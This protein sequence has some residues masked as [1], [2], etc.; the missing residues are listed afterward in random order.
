MIEEIATS[1]PITQAFHAQVPAAGAA[2]IHGE[3]NSQTANANVSQFG[4]M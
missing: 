3:M 1:T 2:M 4:Q